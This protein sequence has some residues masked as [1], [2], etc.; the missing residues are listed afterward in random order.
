M[1]TPLAISTGLLC[2]L[3]V[4]V[5]VTGCT[6]PTGTAPAA[7]PPIPPGQARIWFYRLWE[8]SISLN[9]ANVMLNDAPAGS[10]L[11]S[12]PGMYRDVPPGRYHISAQTYNVDTNQ[13]RDVDLVAGQQVFAK[14]LAVS[15]TSYDGAVTSFRRDNFYV[16]L[17]PPQVALAEIASGPR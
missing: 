2:G 7:A 12:G 15:D 17:M 16:W 11:P 4:A 13:T 14:V 10:V 5:A 1:S 3:A 8:P 9:V 6:T